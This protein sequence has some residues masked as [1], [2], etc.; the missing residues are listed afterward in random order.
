MKQGRCNAVALLLVILVIALPA[1]AVDGTF[2]VTET[3]DV[4]LEYSDWGSSGY[5]GTKHFSGTQTGTIVITDGSYTLLDK[6]GV[7]W[8]SPGQD[9]TSR[10]EP[11]VKL[12]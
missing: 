10:T 6:S 9:L 5:T 2:K 4:T 12:H 3:W 1:W 7:R 8:A 11:R